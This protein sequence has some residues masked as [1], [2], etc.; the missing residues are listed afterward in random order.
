MCKVVVRLLFV[1]AF[2]IKDVRRIKLDLDNIFLFDYLKY[3]EI[4]C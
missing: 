4:N 1:N 3:V 2:N